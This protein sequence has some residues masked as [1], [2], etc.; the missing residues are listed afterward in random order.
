M[1]FSETSMSSNNNKAELIAYIKRL[2]YSEKI[3]EDIIR[4]RGDKITKSE[5][6][7][8]AVAAASKNKVRL[9][10]YCNNKK[11]IPPTPPPPPPPE[12]RFP[13]IPCHF[14]LPQEARFWGFYSTY[15]INT[16]MTFI[17]D[18]T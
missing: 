18:Y 4:M 7:S 10:E 17:E 6:L 15:I 13:L 5:L 1:L 3:A 9:G 8:Y 11:T 2:G 16:L 12:F 14:A